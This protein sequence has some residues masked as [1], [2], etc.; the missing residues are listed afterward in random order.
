MATGM[1]TRAELLLDARL[2]L[3]ERAQQ[4]LL[5]EVLRLALDEAERLTGGTIGFF[6]F[7]S[8]DG[9]TLSLQSWS[10]NTVA[11][12]CSAEGK[13]QHY[14]LAR[15]GVWVDC[16]RLDRPVI[17]NDYEGLAHRRGLPPGHAPIVRELL[18]PVRRGGRIVA[19]LG[20]GNKPTDYDEQDLEAVSLLANLAWDV[21][22]HKR[23]DE[24]L[25][26]QKRDLA[27]AQAVAHVGSWQLDLSENRLTWSDEVY[28]IFG[29]EPG[30]FDATLEAFTEC[31][32]PED[33]E[34]V[35]ASYRQALATGECYEL[36]HRVVRPDGE[37]RVVRERSEEIRDERGEAI[38]SHGTVLDITELAAAQE[39][40]RALNASLEE[41]VRERTAELE[42]SHAELARMNEQ[43]NRLLGMAAHDLRNPLT[44]VQAFAELLEADTLGSL[45]PRQ[46]EVV[47]RIRAASHHMR[48]LVND[49]LDLSKIEAG[50]LELRRAPQDLVAVTREAVATC[51]LLASPKQI[52]VELVA[53]D[54][55]PAVHLDRT[56][57]EQVLS[58]LI[59]NAIKFSHP[60]S[61]VEVSVQRRGGE[62]QLCVRDRGRGIAPE[63][64]GTL[65]R[66]FATDGRPGTGGERATGLGLAIARRMVE[67]HGGRI[68]VTSGPGAGSCF[69][70]ALP[71][72]DGGGSRSP[73]A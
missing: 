71:I 5:D 72:D 39:E 13:G 2:R 12:M 41:R 50:R 56:R 26:Q 46:R 6:H 43:K 64:L 15:A 42:A 1:G 23:A 70:V 37:V 11:K 10:S 73:A 51:Q 52:T 36:V 58:N 7:L 49:L 21:V 16:V 4:G 66:D 53:A 25:E 30:A 32:H 44:A 40:L 24:A 20:T 60:G 35:L 3:A 47:K 57:I 14:P 45:A 68:W 28:R 17:Q 59:G 54:E 34:R 19:I 8:D 48:T 55:I 18:V 9:Q 69:C 27:K 67:A 63:R 65:F 29:R 22:L 38:R 33:R 31:I 61:S 62:A